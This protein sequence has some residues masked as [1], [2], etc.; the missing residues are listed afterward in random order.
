[1]NERFAIGGPAG[2]VGARVEVNSR[3]ANATGSLAG[4][5][6]SSQSAPPVALVATHS[7]I[8]NVAIEPSVLDRLLSNGVGLFSVQIPAGPSGMRP[9]DRSVICR[10]KL[11][12]STTPVGA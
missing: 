9:I 12:A 3:P 10:P 5:Y 2:T 8:F 1:M 7:L 4:L 6:S 11:M